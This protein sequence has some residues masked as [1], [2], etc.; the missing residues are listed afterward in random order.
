MRENRSFARA[1]LNARACIYRDNEIYE[2]EVK[3]LSITGAF[4]TTF[5]PLG[6]NDLVALTIYHTLTPEILSNVKAKVA[7]VT[8]MGVGLQFEKPLI[9]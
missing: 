2:G 4:I 5:S 7:R 8:D 9:D 3:D 6:R 1:K